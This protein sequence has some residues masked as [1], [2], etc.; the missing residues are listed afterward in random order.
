MVQLPTVAFLANGGG[1]GRN[2][3]TDFSANSLVALGHI[4]RRLPGDPYV[5]V[6]TV[7]GC[8]AFR[9]SQK[10]DGGALPSGSMIEAPSTS[11]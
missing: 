4:P 5:D 6:H 9:H 8:L 7:L 1:P 2:Q 10:A 11:V 3:F